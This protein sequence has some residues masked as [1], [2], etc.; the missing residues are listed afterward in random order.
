[1]KKV[2]AAT[3]ILGLLSSPAMAWGDREQGILTGIAGLWVFQQLDKAGRPQND[4]VIVQQPPV[5]IYQQ[6][7]PII[8][9]QPVQYCDKNQV[10]DRFGKQ[11][12]ITYCY[13][14]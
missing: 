6:Q 4:P 14:Q 10:W 8:V 2:I 1:M 5:V 9:Q 12:T 7:A 11:R 3:L 13:Y